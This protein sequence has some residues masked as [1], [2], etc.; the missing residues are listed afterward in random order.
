MTHIIF[1][2]PETCCRKASNGWKI[3]HGILEISVTAP[4]NARTTV[5][6]SATTAEKVTEPG[7]QITRSKDVK[8]IGTEHV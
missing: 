8:V 1:R 3:L 5:F 6:I 7:P 4:T 2:E